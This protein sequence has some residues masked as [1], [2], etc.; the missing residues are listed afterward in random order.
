MSSTRPDRLVALLAEED[1]RLLDATEDVEARRVG[2]L[3]REDAV[4]QF[5]EPAEPHVRDVGL[6]RA[7]AVLLEAR[8]AGV[9]LDPAEPLAVGGGARRLEPVAV[10]LVPVDEGVDVRPAV[11]DA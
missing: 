9:V 2:A 1:D 4:D 11:G 6:D 8:V 5:V 10:D 3:A 7:E